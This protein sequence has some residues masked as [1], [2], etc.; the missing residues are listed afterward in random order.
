MLLCIVQCTMLLLLIIIV[1]FSLSTDFGTIIVL[2]LQRSPILEL[3]VSSGINKE[4]QNELTLWAKQKNRESNLQHE[5]MVVYALA[6]PTRPRDSKP[7][8]GCIVVI[9]WC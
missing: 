4:T 6:T 5:T 7:T 2:R 1:V 8:R 9:L 3:Y